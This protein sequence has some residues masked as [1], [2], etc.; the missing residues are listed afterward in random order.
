MNQEHTDFG[1][2]R[3]PFDEKVR[4]VD[5]VF[6]SVAQRYDLMND[7]MSF[8]LHRIWKRIAVEIAGVRRGARILDLAAGTGDLARLWRA[9]SG[10][11]GLVVVA[12]LNAAM[13]ERGRR[14]LVDAG[15]ADGYACVR[16]DA[17]HLPF[18]DAG[19]DCVSIAFGLRNVAHKEQAL[20]AMYGVLRP[21]GQ[22]LVLEFSSLRIAALKPLYDAYS[23]R[24]L[25]WLG[26]LIA[27]DAASYRYLAE[28]IRVHPD[29]ETLKAMMEEA[30]FARCAY[31]NLFGGVVA[32]HRG[33][34][35]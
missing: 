32:L 1:Y 15:I 4:R 34:R 8:G 24:V 6:T 31:F 27:R 11:T 16:A 30:G 22:A 14:R 7:L 33:Y 5:A 23:F 2:Q 3:V 19:F 28:S 13:L 18:P 20:A 25:P 10:P 26:R 21:G 29:Q 35:L 9:R 12:D 17:Q